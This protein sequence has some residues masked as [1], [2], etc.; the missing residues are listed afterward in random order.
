MK[1]KYI[2]YIGMVGLLLSC[3]IKSHALLDWE[4]TQIV[5]KA[6]PLDS[7]ISATFTFTNIG[8]DTVTIKE[9]KSSCGCTT[10]ALEERVYASGESGKIIATLDMASRQGLQ[11]KTIQVHTDDEDQPT[12]LTMKTLIPK[13]LNIQPAFVFWKRGKEPDIKTIDLEVGLEEL[14]HITRAS[15]DNGNI[16]VQF[17]EVEAGK[18]Y[19]IMLF[20]TNTD[21]VTKA[22]IT[23]KT[24]FPE[25]KPKT[26]YVYAHV[27]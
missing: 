3:S 18:K 6:N 9:I 13:I 14:M 4:T 11:S 22:K 16:E 7:S 23:L 20:P 5:Q 10:A 26:F 19:Q 25:D 24:D 8:D 1:R 27:K 2:K 21:E 12:I 15:S 17:N